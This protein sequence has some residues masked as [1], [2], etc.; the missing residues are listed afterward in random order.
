MTMED[1]EKR[2][3]VDPVTGEIVDPE[4][5]EVIEDH[6]IAMGREWRQYS[7]EEYLTRSRASGSITFKV[8][9]HGL[10]TYIGSKAKTWSS[11]TEVKMKMIAARR[12]LAAL[13]ERVR[14]EKVSRKLISILTKINEIV[15]KLELPNTVAE[16]ASI[17]CRKFM[18][19]VDVRTKDPVMIAAACVA[20]AVEIEGIPITK[21][22][23]A[24]ALNIKPQRLLKFVMSLKKLGLVRS[25]PIDP[26]AIVDRLASALNV[27][28][29]AVAIA[30]AILVKAKEAG[31]IEGRNPLGLAASAL[32]IAA[33][34]TNSRVAQ[35]II[36]KKVGAS[37][38]MVRNRYR[39]MCDKLD[40]EVML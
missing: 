4:T 30:K 2:Y 38:V 19:A 40:I 8:H 27:N 23:I 28:P 36:E 15:S 9:D 29:A 32:Y 6:P 24:K 37:Q 34:I 1:V 17:V 5:G 11:A 35:R 26:R 39:E 16:T 10:H 22:E 7:Y 25:R 31:I 14:T 13:N 33:A 20:T 3:V 12:R 21:T 18:E